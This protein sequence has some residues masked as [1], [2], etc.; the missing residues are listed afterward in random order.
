[1]RIIS[2][3]AR[4]EKGS[5]NFGMRDEDWDIY[6]AISKENGDSDSEMENEKLI[7]YEDILRHHDPM[8][9]EPAVV[10]SG[11]AESHQV[12]ENSKFFFDKINSILR[13]IHENM[14]IIVREYKILSSHFFTFETSQLRMKTLNRP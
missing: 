2:Q 3:L 12:S 9:E 7:E 13:N 8:F 4:K 11:A 1:M 10:V 14:P 6:K 5:D